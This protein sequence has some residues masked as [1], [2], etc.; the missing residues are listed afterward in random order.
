VYDQTLLPD[1]PE[2]SHQTY[3]LLNA[4]AGYE[5]TWQGRR[6]GVDLMGKNLTDEHY[7][8]SQSTRGR[9]RELLLTISAKF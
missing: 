9:P 2:S 6:M 8:P 7:R 1:S 3:T 4:K 5:W